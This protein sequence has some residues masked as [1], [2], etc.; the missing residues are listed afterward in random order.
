M[1]MCRIRLG[2]LIRLGWLVVQIL[3]QNIF[4]MVKLIVEE[5]ALVS[6]MRQ[7]LVTKE[8]LGLLRLHRLL[9]LKVYIKGK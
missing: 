4:F 2:G 8:R 5:E 1:G 9:I 7:V 6:T 3:M